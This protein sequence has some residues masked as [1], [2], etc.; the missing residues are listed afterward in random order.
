M[1]TSEIERLLELGR[2]L[3]TVSPGL[4]AGYLPS[5]ESVVA[6]TSN[7]AAV[8][9]TVGTYESA[10]FA[11]KADYRKSG[12]RV[13]F[14]YDCLAEVTVAF[15]D[16]TA[17]LPPAVEFRD[18]GRE[19]RHCA[20]LTSAADEL[21]L[22]CLLLSQQPALHPAEALDEPHRPAPSARRSGRTVDRQVIPHLLGYLAALRLPLSV[23]LNNSGCIHCDDGPLDDVS[24][25]GDLILVRCG[26]TTLSCDP[27]L[28]GSW[29]VRSTDHDDG[30]LLEAL[31]PDNRRQF[32]FTCAPRECGNARASW[33]TILESLP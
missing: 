32:H 18:R 4:A 31:C 23:A 29:R 14:N 6:V 5:F 12:L 33:K 17:R 21:A 16:H 10:R 22:E 2:K 11:R 13:Y 3:P 7:T 24:Q 9:T 30:L 8:M 19:I 15:A 1:S 25:A 27:A 20:Y 28:I 26:D